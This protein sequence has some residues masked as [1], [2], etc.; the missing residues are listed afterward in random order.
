MEKTLMKKNPRKQNG[1]EV[2]DVRLAA[3]GVVPLGKREKYV[4]TYVR[5]GVGCA[6]CQLTTHTSIYFLT[7]G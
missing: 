3:T 5:K 7:Y 4:P 2:D 6:R 1:E